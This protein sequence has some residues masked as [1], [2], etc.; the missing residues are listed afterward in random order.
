MP[1]ATCH[2]GA[3]GG[4][5]RANS[6]VVTKAPAVISWPLTIAKITSHAIPTTKVTI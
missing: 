3:S 2:N 4:Q 6:T 1:K 5:H